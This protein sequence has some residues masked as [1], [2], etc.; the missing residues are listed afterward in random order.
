M[1]TKYTRTIKR[2]IELTNFLS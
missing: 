2:V 1:N